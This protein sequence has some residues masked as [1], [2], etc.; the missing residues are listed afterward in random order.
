VGVQEIMKLR[1]FVIDDEKSIRHTFKMYLENK[2]HEV[3]V[4]EDPLICDIYHGC[5]CQEDYPC[6]DLLLIDYLM[7]K[8]TGLEFIKMMHER[9]CKGNP[10]NKYVMSGNTNVL[11]MQLV[12]EVGCNILQKPV[13][14]SKLDQIVEEVQS[15]LSPDRQLTCLEKMKEKAESYYNASC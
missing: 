7:P 8:M 15:R 9:G 2:G 3:L 1:V 6:G 12:K 14:F 4:A 5:D 11:D 13:K 10:A